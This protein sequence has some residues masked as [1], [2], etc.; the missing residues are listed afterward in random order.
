MSF[1]DVL[2][3]F[4]FIGLLG[5]VVFGGVYAMHKIPKKLEKNVAVVQ[6]YDKEVKGNMGLTL[7]GNIN[8]TIPVVHSNANVRID[9]S[10]LAN[11]LIQ[12]NSAGTNLTAQAVSTNKVVAG[13]SV[14]KT[15]SGATIEHRI[16][17]EKTVSVKG[18]I[19][20]INYPSVPYRLGEANC[21]LVPYTAINVFTT[22]GKRLSLVSPNVIQEW[23]NVD[24]EFV[25]VPV[26]D[27]LP[28]GEIMLGSSF[29]NE[30]EKVYIYSYPQHSCKI[31][32]QGVL[33]RDIKY[34]EEVK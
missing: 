10:R 25:Y 16:N 23:K 34:P 18:M 6:N 24:A 1:S 14:R 26:K 32:T 31:K 12:S 4:A 13:N 28:I 33:V 2:E 21:I 30:N 29:F 9:N 17:L 7:N 3:F 22:D 5:S 8:Y 15:S 11:S 19:K 27:G 20:D